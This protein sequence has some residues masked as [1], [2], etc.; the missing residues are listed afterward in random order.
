M[1]ISKLEHW[2]VGW[3]EGPRSRSRRFEQE[4]DA[5]TF[6]GE[7]DGQGRCRPS[8]RKLD[9]WQVRWREGGRGSRAHKWTFE[10]KRDAER[11]EREV[12]RRKELGE[13]ALWEQRNRC[14]EELARE[15]WAKYAVPNLAELTLDGYEPILAKHVVPRL[16]DYRVGEVTPEVVADFRAQLE[17]AGVG[18]H[19][20]RVSMVVLQ[21]MFKQAIRWRWIEANPVKA[22]EK[23]SGKRE[24]AVVCLAPAQVE[25]IR[26]R[27]IEWG[28]LYAAT[29]VSLVAYQGLRVP[30]E[31]LALEVRHVRANTLLIEQ[32]NIKGKI[33]PGQKVRYSRPRSPRLL[34]PVRRDVTEYL[35]A[36]GIRQGL[37]FP[38]QDG[39]PWKVHDYK[40]WTR[41]VWKKAREGAG[42]EAM[43]PYDLR[44]AYASL[45]IRAGA[46]IPE[47]AEELGHAPQ[48]TV[49][50]Y[51][52]VIRELQGEPM[53]SAEEQI[54][55]ARRGAPQPA[56][57]SG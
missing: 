50:T 31:V 47:L 23:P 33:V 41:R 32:R 29:M 53:V 27:L 15:W 26:G 51:T 30:E 19:A 57:A 7:L 6:A 21:A 14:V 28:K 54:E 10:R 9:R 39:E 4:R 34:D 45:R 18:R 35:V 20:V 44:H 16:G 13:L 52:H 25:A 43:P 48:M 2:E 22:V 8:I 36:T 55:L 49:G 56:E 12:K 37:L 1:S 38:R 11:F 42:I 40:N 3:H 17:S 5:R 46:S 24:R